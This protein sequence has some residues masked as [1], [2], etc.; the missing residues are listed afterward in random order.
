VVSTSTSRPAG[1]GTFFDVITDEMPFVV[2]SLLAGFDRTGARVRQVVH[3]VVAVRRDESGALV[4]VLT[5][6]AV[7]QSRRGTSAELWIR[8][9]VD[10]LPVDEA[11]E[12]AAELRSV[13]RDVRDV[14]LD[15]DSIVEVARSAAAELLGTGPPGVTQSDIQDAARLIEWL[16]DGRFALLGYRRYDNDRGRRAGSSR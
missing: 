2:E 14:V 1:S 11:K 15:Q 10:P 6:S 8:V 13:L 5:P 4:E 3:P 7:D 16:V 12:L 9:E